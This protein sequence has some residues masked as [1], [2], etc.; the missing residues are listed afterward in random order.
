LVSVRGEPVYW[1]TG[2]GAILLPV[3]KAGDVIFL[4]W[5]QKTRAK[6]QRENKRGNLGISLKASA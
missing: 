2:L 1:R 4:M 5:K 3:H 6:E